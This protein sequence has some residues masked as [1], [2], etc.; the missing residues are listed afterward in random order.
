[1]QWAAQEGVKKSEKQTRA[2]RQFA[3][4]PVVTKNAQEKKVV[5]WLEYYWQK[6]RHTGKFWAN[7]GMPVPERDYV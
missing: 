4:L 7:A 6:Q 2:V 1:M 5:L 3:L